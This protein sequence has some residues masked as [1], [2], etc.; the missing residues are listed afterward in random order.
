VKDEFGTREA[1]IGALGTPL[2]NG[3]YLASLHKSEIARCTCTFQSSDCKM[4]IPDR[5][6]AHPDCALTPS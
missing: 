1:D 5:D 3:T 4:N 6:L 2:V